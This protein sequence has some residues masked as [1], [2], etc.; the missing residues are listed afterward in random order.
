[1]DQSLVRIVAQ[2]FLYL[3]QHL[4][5]LCLSWQVLRQRQLS[6]SQSLRHLHFDQMC[7]CFGPLLSPIDLFHWTS[8][9][10]HLQEEVVAA[11]HHQT[12]LHLR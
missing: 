8:W 6:L 9:H 4:R 1:M 2:L 11:R 10:L 7:L 5:D 12:L 3:F